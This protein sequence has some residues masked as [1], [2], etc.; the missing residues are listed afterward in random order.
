MDSSVGQRFMQL[1][2]D[3]FTFFKD[4]KNHENVERYYV[5]R[6]C[7]S[8][9]TDFETLSNYNWIVIKTSLNPRY[10]GLLM[11]IFHAMYEKHDLMFLYPDEIIQDGGCGVEG[12]KCI[13][14]IEYDDYHA[15]GSL[16]GFEKYITLDNYL[17]YLE[18][19]F[20]NCK[21]IGESFETLPTSE[22]IICNLSA[23][24]MKKYGYKKLNP[25]KQQVYTIDDVY[26]LLSSYREWYMTE[27][28]NSEE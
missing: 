26:K 4:H 28:N 15:Q 13:F 11:D 12:C 18:Y 27:M 5:H 3:L 23:K 1:L 20:F 10:I 6:E 21:F 25:R 19:K 24:Q 14:H 22:K 7:D 9:T 8:N 17:K 16:K 2:E